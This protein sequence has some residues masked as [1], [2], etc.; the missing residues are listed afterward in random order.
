[1]VEAGLAVD[2]ARWHGEV[3]VFRVLR[4]ELRPE[5]R[6]EVAVL[7]AVL[8][9]DAAAR[10][11]WLAG[12]RVHTEKVRLDMVRTSEL[13][14]EPV[15]AGMDARSIYLSAQWSAQGGREQHGRRT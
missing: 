4:G 3:G 12:E 11:A 8:A 15:S 13:V 14:D 10:E 9:L 6:A 1:M 5:S 7:G 2:G